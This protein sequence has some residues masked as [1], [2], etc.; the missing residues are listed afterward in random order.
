[1]NEF[2]TLI[3]PLRYLR[4]TYR[5]GTSFFVSIFTHWQMNFNPRS[6]K[7]RNIWPLETV[8]YLTTYEI[9]WHFI[10]NGNSRSVW[11]PFCAVFEFCRELFCTLYAHEREVALAVQNGGLAH[12]DLKFIQLKLKNF[13]EIWVRPIIS[14]DISFWTLKEI[15]KEEEKVSRLIHSKTRRGY[16]TLLCPNISTIYDM[17]HVDRAVIFSFTKWG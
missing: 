6:G 4:V 11:K 7:F 1:M 8:S 5:V 14:G 13:C 15:N 9:F 10:R 2:F 17:L 16:L 3:F 12:W